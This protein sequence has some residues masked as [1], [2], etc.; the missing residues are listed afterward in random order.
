MHPRGLA[1]D[2]LY[3]R[4][5]LNGIYGRSGLWQFH[6]ALMPANLITL[7]HFSVSS[8]IN[9]PKSPGETTTPL[10]P[11]RQTALSASDRRGRLDFLVQPS[12]E[13]V[14]M[15]APN[16]RTAILV[17]LVPLQLPDTTDATAR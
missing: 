16:Y 5:S 6:C 3:D 17:L 15:L 2:T 4:H 7:P 13:D 10:L 14:K 9:F 11:D 1:R 12:L 8:A